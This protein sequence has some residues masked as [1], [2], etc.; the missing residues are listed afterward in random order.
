MSFPSFPKF[1]AGSARRHE[2]NL[3]EPPSA[4]CSTD[5]NGSY[6]YLRGLD[7]PARGKGYLWEAFFSAW[8]SYLRVDDSDD[9][10][11][12]N[13]HISPPSKRDLG[14]PHAFRWRRPNPAHGQESRFAPDLG[15]DVYRGPDIEAFDERAGIMEHEPWNDSRGSRMAAGSRDARPR[16]RVRSRERAPRDR[17][18]LTSPTCSPVL[19]RSRPPLFPDSERKSHT[20]RICAASTLSQS[21]AG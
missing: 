7:G 12:P 9:V 19:W 16:S 2:R 14:V 17:D 3:A 8:D 13:A 20:G 11:K 4:D 15:L 21:L 18:L 5:S 6:Q 10:S 1:A